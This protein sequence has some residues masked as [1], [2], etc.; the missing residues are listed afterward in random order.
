MNEMFA[1]SLAVSIPLALMWAAYRLAFSGRGILAMNRIMLLGIYIIALM[2]FPMVGAVERFAHSVNAVSQN[3][4]I[5]EPVSSLVETMGVFSIIWAV[6]CGIVFVLTL[7]DWIRIALVLRSSDK[8]KEGNMTLYLTK[9]KRVSPFSIFRAVVMSRD[10]YEGYRMFVLA[11]EAGHIKLRH[12]LDLFLAQALAILCWYNPAAWLMKRDL[13]TIHE[14]QA[15]AYAIDGGC[16]LAEYQTLLV[17]KA[18][19]RVCYSGLLNHFGGS[20]LKKRIMKMDD[21]GANK[22]KTG[23]RYGVV[24]ASLFAGGL[25][26]C[27][28][29]ARAVLGPA[30]FFNREEKMGKSFPMEIYV[31]GERVE[32]E[33]LNEIP[34]G[35]IKA[36]TIDK[37]KERI[38]V[39]LK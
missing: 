22:I 25:I 34:V 24:A 37:S 32:Y 26:L 11:H 23:W 5:G 9:D 33:N 1:Y 7:V 4:S 20:V 13:K 16:D 3:L 28:P 39:S 31:E 35:E 19:N 18:A 15:D 2:L 27:T 17:R 36:I 38:D 12:S 8:I 30:N 21:S 10:D 6:G 29:A 14:F